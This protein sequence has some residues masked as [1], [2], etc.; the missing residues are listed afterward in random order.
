LYCV[1]FEYIFFTVKMGIFVS[2]RCFVVRHHEGRIGPLLCTGSA[3]ES[4]F[5]QTVD[6]ST[7]IAQDAKDA[8]KETKCRPEQKDC[9]SALFG[10]RFATIGSQFFTQGSHQGRVPT[11]PPCFPSYLIVDSEKQGCSRTTAILSTMEKRSWLAHRVLVSVAK[12]IYTRA[13]T[14]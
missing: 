2:R 7:K 4:P 13:T 1:R 8:G 14:R 3:V 9:N 11:I 6:R 5:R 12:H 10:R